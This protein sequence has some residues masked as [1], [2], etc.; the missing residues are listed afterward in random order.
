MCVENKE[1]ED[2]RG[3][4]K[5]GRPIS[6]I[7]PRASNQAAKTRSTTLLKIKW[8]EDFLP[9]FTPVFMCMLKAMC[10]IPQTHTLE[11]IEIS[12]Y[13][14]GLKTCIFPEIIISLGSTGHTV[15]YTFMHLS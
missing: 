7:E 1:R 5:K 3:R 2:R 15:Q 12:C 9:A 6:G 13:S 4:R 8:I 14:T 10:E 11:R